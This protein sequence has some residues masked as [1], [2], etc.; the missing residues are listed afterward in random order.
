MKALTKKDFQKIRY[1]EFMFDSAYHHDYM[2][3]PSIRDMDMVFDIYDE[4]TGT[5]HSRNYS[6]SHCQLQLYRLMAP[7][8]FAAKEKY[9]NTK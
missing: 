4:I 7:H 3:A 5:R 9:E 1:Q 2:H 6:C 8:Y